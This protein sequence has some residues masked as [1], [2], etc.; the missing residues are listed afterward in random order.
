MLFYFVLVDRCEVLNLNIVWLF[1]YVW[2][3]YEQKNNILYYCYY[4]RYAK[5][6][7]AR[8]GGKLWLAQP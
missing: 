6:V 4:N 1:W 3:K 2:G 5:P 8:A 7:L